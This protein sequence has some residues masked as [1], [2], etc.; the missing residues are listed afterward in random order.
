MVARRLASSAALVPPGPPL[1]VDVLVV[2][3]TAL[4]PLAAAGTASAGDA[5]LDEVGSEQELRGVGR[6]SAAP[7]ASASLAPPRA[8]AAA[9]SFVLWA[10]ARRRTVGPLLPGGSLTLQLWAL[11]RDVGN[12]DLNRFIFSVRPADGATGVLEF[13]VP[14]RLL[15]SV[16]SPTALSVVPL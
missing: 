9:P 6:P 13:R 16:R 10:G 3:T 8:P 2:D 5:A 4:P 15:T 14:T 7:G 11:L 1:V 12:V